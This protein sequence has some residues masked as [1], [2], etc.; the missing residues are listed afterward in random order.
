MPCFEVAALQRYVR[1]PRLNPTAPRC[2]WSNL[3]QNRSHRALLPFCLPAAAGAPHNQCDRAVG[4]SAWAWAARAR[5]AQAR[6][7]RAWAPGTSSGHRWPRYHPAAGAAAAP[8]AGQGQLCPGSGAKR[9]AGRGMGA[10]SELTRPTRRRARAG[11]IDAPSGPVSG[12]SRSRATG[13]TRAIR[14]HVAAY[15]YVLL[16][17]A[18]LAVLCWALGTPCSW[19]RTRTRTCSRALPKPRY[20][21][22][23]SPPFS[24]GSPITRKKSSALC[25]G[26]RGQLG[27]CGSTWA[28]GPRS[29]V[30]RLSRPLSQKGLYGALAKIYA[31]QYYCEHVSIRTGPW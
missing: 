19:L 13:F 25:L 26:F 8:V 11:E 2:C 7:A 16:C 4:G 21:R 14:G 17:P 31:V 22:L 12:R 27:G 20:I 1:L 28:G 23:S 10:L 24:P 9:G 5:V 3:P 6:A 30:L 29:R 18:P 15:A